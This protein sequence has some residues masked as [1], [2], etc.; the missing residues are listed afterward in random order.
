M[1]KREFIIIE[2]EW[3]GPFLFDGQELLPPTRLA[4]F[5]PTPNNAE[6]LEA[7]KLIQQEKYLGD[8]AI[9]MTVAEKIAL[10]WLSSYGL[11]QIYGQHPLYGSDQLLY[12]GKTEGEFSG[13]LGGHAKDW[14][15]EPDEL[16]VYIGRLGAEEA[17]HQ[18]E[19]KKK[20]E[21]I[22]AAESLLIY[23]L[24]PAGNDRDKKSCKVKNTFVVNVGRYK[25]LPSIVGS[26]QDESKYYSPDTWLRNQAWKYL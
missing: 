19:S 3:A 16:R 11:Y 10:I 9:G 8:A 2:I 17:D 6:K 24:W 23:S 15:W 26:L 22:K 7:E 14:L 5:H 1:A 18:V 21:R 4:D 20:R 12:I 25:A 13:R